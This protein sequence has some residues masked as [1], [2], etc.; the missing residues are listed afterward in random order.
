M[1]QILQQPTFLYVEDDTFSREIMQMMLVSLG[2]PQVALFENSIDFLARLEQLTP[3]PDVILL[4]VHVQ[5]H[6]G[7]EM[8]GILRKHPVYGRKS[9]IAITASVMNEEI[10]RLKEEGFNGAI[11]KPL[12]FENFADLIQRVL[13]GETVWHVS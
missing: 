12:D 6:N 13:A 10:A 8:L 2:F 4:D 1:G 11:G 9:V 7:F 3:I 5:P